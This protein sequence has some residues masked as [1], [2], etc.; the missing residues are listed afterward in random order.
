MEDKWMGY[1]Y[2]KLKFENH[3]AIIV[4]PEEGTANG[5]LAVKTEYWEAFPE[6]I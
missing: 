3:H 4:C 5:Y 2:R 1:Q 6:A